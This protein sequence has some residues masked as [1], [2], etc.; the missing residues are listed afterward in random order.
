MSFSLVSQNVGQLFILA[1]QKSSGLLL[2]IFV[3]F[4]QDGRLFTFARNDKVL[5]KSVFPNVG[6]D[7]VCVCVCA[8]VYSYITEQILGLKDIWHKHSQSWKFPSSVHLSL[9]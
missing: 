7:G 2:Q 8:R 9:C 6:P 1:L 5:Q 3:L 4:H